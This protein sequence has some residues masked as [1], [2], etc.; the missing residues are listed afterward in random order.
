M[1]IDPVTMRRGRLLNT[2]R[3]LQLFEGPE[4]TSCATLWEPGELFALVENTLGETSVLVE[5]LQD[6]YRAWLKLADA[7]ALAE[8]EVQSDRA[9]I[10]VEPSEA[11]SNQVIAFCQAAS[12]V[13]HQYAWGGNHGP[14]YDCSGL[15]QGAFRAQGILLV[16]DAYMQELF[17]QPVPMGSQRLGDLVFFGENRVT[18]V[19]IMTSSSTYIHSSGAKNGHN[20]I[21]EDDLLS[22][23]TDVQRHYRALH[24]G[25][26]RVVRGFKLLSRN[27]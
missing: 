22:P 13:P 3:R 10:D 5:G 25:F 26:G 2:S 6:G 15:V 24:R 8:S 16:R 9:I 23:L 1:Q 17:T 4:S 20:G 27:R 11:V 14:D 12:A 18:H 7:D 19:G 21:R